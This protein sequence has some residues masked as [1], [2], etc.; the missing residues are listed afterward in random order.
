M[1]A[2][3]LVRLEGVAGRRPKELSGG[4]Q[5]RVALARVIVI[6]PRLLLLDEPLSNLDAK[7]RRNMQ[8]EI[9]RLQESLHI[10]TVH[11]THDQSEALS[12]SDRIVV[13]NQGKIEQIGT[14]EDIYV[15]P[16]NSFVADFIGESNLLEGYITQLEGGD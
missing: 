11:V 10:T 4:Q 9:R 2:L 12:L 16:Y 14:P 1:A 15:H 5:Q 7:L 8:V 6:Q 3:E 13:M